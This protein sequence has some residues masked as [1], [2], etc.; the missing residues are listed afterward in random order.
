[1][2]N[3]RPNNRVKRALLSQK[4]RLDRYCCGISQLHKHHVPV[5]VRSMNLKM[6][7]WLA[8][9]SVSVCGMIQA[10]DEPKSEATVATPAVGDVLPAFEGTDDQGLPWKSADHVGKK[11]LVLYFYPGDFT[12]GCIKQV[13]AYRDGLKKLEELGAEIVG[14]SGDEIA[15]HKL[16]KETFDIKH[17]LLS[18]AKGELAKLLS[19][20]VGAGGRANPTTPDRKPLLDAE[21]K[22]I[23][24]VREVTLERWTIVVDRDGKIASRRKIANPMTDSEEVVKIVEALPK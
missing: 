21:G 5:K 8:A 10:A 18:D 9:I 16:F 23:P 11:V 14:V 6:I 24:I 1:M 13:E 12:G 7:C 20:P 3:R 15:T 22:R 4:R 2:T 19:V 17:V